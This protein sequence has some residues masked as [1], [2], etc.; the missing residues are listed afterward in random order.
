MTDQKIK[1]TFSLIT[2]TINYPKLIDD[3]VKDAKNH[4]K[5]LKEIIIVGDIKTPANVNYF[6]KQIEKKY[7]IHCSYLSPKDQITF[8][9]KYPS[10]KNY[11]PWNCIQRRNVGLLK[12]YENNSD[13]AV[14]IDDDNFIQ[15]SNYFK[16]HEH[17]GSVVKI[18]IIDSKTNF[19]NPC[20]MLEDTKK[21]KFYHRGHPLSKRWL[22]REEEKKISQ[23]DGKV[24]VNA[25]LWFGDP[26]VDALT[27]LFYPIEVKKVSKFF[28]DKTSPSLSN[29]SP[30]N[31]QNT[32]IQR[33]LIPAYFLFPY[34]GRYDDIWASYI[35]KKI[36][37]ARNEFITYGHPIVFQ[38]RNPH[39]YLKDF[40]L[41]KF[42]LRFN[43]CFLEILSEIKIQKDDSYQKS[44][45][46]IASFF[47]KE[48][49][50]FLK[51]YKFDKNSFK[52]IVE[53]MNRWVDCF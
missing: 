46:K 18:R 32:A 30:F 21:I 42:G 47:K 31:S 10:I 16:S 9:K 48:N 25:G 49:N 6:S 38:N 17:V 36:A 13:I 14:V 24:V 51:K 44:Y 2:T 41:E 19:W 8:L 33:D 35:I 4:N 34:I 52:A 43:D 22:S 12:F 1:K 29:Y 27:R 20:E 26:D 23:I 3:Y 11:I 7:K 5:L 53:G 37:N 45:L 50:H 15:K 28:K 39:D 40:E